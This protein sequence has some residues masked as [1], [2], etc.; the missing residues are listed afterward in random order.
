LPVCLLNR[1]HFKRPPP[2]LL[3][4]T[5]KGSPPEE[6]QQLKSLLLGVQGSV[7]AA[8]EEAVQAILALPPSLSP[9]VI[10][11]KARRETVSGEEGLQLS[12]LNGDMMGCAFHREHRGHV[13]MLLVGTSLPVRAGVPLK[14][15]LQIGVSLVEVHMVSAGFQ[16]PSRARTTW[17][18]VESDGGGGVIV[19]VNMQ[20]VPKHLR[21]V[22]EP[23]ASEKREPAV[24]VVLLIIDGIE[25]SL[26]P[27]QPARSLRTRE[28][29][30]H[31]MKIVGNFGIQIVGHLEP[32]WIAV[33]CSL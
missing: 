22:P 4:H 16:H 18:E 7:T 10:D 29:P 26:Q 13:G 12:P 8:R 33:A 20:V 21:Q 6:A 30:N 27:R 25:E 32:V 5:N 31:H 17:D 19:R 23:G 14:G 24:S 9:L 3:V 1:M 2:P 15:D 28:E 11:R